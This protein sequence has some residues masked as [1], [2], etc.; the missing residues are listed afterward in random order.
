MSQLGMQMPGSQRGIRPRMNVYTG[1]AL[2][3]VVCLAAAV[4]MVARAGMQIGPK[5]ESGIMRAI[6]VHGDKVELPE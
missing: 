4:V 6:S 1:L 2:V 3:A 5:S